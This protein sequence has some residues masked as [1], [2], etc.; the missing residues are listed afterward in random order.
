MVSTKDEPDSSLPPAVDGLLR[1]HKRLDG[2]END[3]SHASSG[4][5]RKISTKLLV[6]ALQAGSL[7][8]KQG[9]TIKSI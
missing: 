8:G 9:G 4:V 6:A 1:V 7:T 3:F 5:A 2:L